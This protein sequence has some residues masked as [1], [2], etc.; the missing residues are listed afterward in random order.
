MGTTPR[1]I[2]DVVRLAKKNKILHFTKEISSA[3]YFAKEKGLIKEINGNQY[4]ITDNGIRYLD[5]LDFSALHQQKPT[6]IAATITNISFIKNIP[7][8]HWALLIAIM[9]LLVTIW[10]LFK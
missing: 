8:K 9:T 1:Q 10:E 4:M 7:N 5:A 6:L 2:E 3:I